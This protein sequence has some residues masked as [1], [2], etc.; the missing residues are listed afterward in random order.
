MTTNYDDA[1][2]RAFETQA[3]R[4]TS[5]YAAYAGSRA[6]RPRPPR[7]QAGAGSEDVSWLRARRANGAAEDPRRGRPRSRA[8]RQLRH[9]RGP[10]HRLRRAD[11]CLQPDPSRADGEDALEP[12]PLPRLRDARLEPPRHSPPHLV[13]A[14]AHVHVVGDPEGAGPSR[15]EFWDRHG[16]DIVD[17]SLD[18]WVEGMEARFS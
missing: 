10:L 9:H 3:R 13:A 16:V 2:E 1:L 12:L 18:E 4:S 11:E 15:R 17:V 7:R 8:G 14:D 6:I 5:Y